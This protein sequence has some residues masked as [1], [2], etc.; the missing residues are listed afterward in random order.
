MIVNVN[1]T[2]LGHVPPLQHE[3]LPAGAGDAPVEREPACFP[4][5]GGTRE[6]EVAFLQRID[7][8]AGSRVTGPA[9]IEQPDTTTVLPPGTQARVHEFGHLIITACE[10]SEHERA[11]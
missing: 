2:G 8:G 3:P 7:L 1:A 10:D 11:H 4:A 6:F 9:V 5:E